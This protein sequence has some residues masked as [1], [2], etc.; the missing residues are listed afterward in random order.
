MREIEIE[1]DF[2]RHDS[3]TERAD[4]LFQEHRQEI[5]RNT[6]Q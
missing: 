2:N 4:E 6:D 1:K 3:S 5:F